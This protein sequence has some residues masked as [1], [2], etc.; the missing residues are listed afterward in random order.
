MLVVLT[1]MVMTLS[2]TTVAF[3]DVDVTFRANSCMVQGVLDTNDV[4]TDGDGLTGVDL[5]GTVQE[6]ASGSNW[7]PGGDPMNSDGGDYW[8]LTVT[9]PDAVIGDTLE[10]K[11]GFTVLNLDGTITSSW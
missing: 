6:Y 5:R 2:F 4:S 1:V 10:F 7:T 8:S 9:F 11:F 3:A